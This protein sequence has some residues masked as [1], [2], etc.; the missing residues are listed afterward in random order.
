MKSQSTNYYDTFIEV[1]ED[2]PVLS[3]AVPPAKEVN[4]SIAKLQ[5]DILN[6]HPYRF[7]SDEV[8]FAVFALRKEVPEESLEEQ[9]Q[10]FFSKGQACFRASPLPK[11]YGWGIHSNKDGKIAL[12]G[13]ETAEYQ[14][15]VED[16][17][18]RKLKAMR[19]KRKE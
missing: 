9:R 10:I 1:A 4:P 3:G 14:K 8:L 2:C 15:F 19:S 17:S 12:Y 16:T 18:L 13:V 6:D 5:Y 7:S 11:S